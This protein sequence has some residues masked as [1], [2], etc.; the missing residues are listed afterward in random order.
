MLGGIYGPIG[1]CFLNNKVDEA[2][3]LAISFKN[4]FK[5]NLFIEIMRH[6]FEEEELI[7]KIFK[8]VK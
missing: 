6:G 3:N 7:E 4:N 2:R 1:I 8:F 5:D